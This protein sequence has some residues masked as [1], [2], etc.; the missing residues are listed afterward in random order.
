MSERLSQKFE[1]KIESL[2]KFEREYGFFLREA[3]DGVFLF[4]DDRIR[5]TNKRFDE[6]FGH[7]KR[8]PLL[9]ES[10]RALFFGKLQECVKR[11]QEK[12]VRSEKLPRFELTVT[13]DD[14]KKR[15]L[16]VAVSLV[17]YKK[18]PAILGIA[19]NI[20]SRN[21][22]SRLS[23]GFLAMAAHEVRTALTLITGYNRLLLAKKT[24]SL[25][26]PQYK[27]VKECNQSCDRFSKFLNEVLELLH[28]DAG[29]MKL[30]NRQED[31]R[32]S[33]KNVLRELG[34]EA[35]QKNIL[36]VETA[37]KGGLPIKVPM[38]R[39]KI[40]LVLMN[41]IKN[42]IQYTPR[43]GKIKIQPSISSKGSIRVCI[44]DTGIGVPPEERDTIFQE[45]KTG[46]NSKTNHGIGLGLAICRK[47]IELHGGKIW[48]ESRKEEGGSRFIFSLPSLRS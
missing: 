30:N 22:F 38:D 32:Q 48:V 20:S 28:L 46:R 15:E 25:T 3:S 16:E 5:L 43:G 39:N 10:G 44:A 47:I 33:I 42:A 21:E 23:S 12:A 27:I 26:P 34:P 1:R 24:G 4:Q 13:K 41:L 8:L 40:E 31:I 18:K 35:K 14:G 17:E 11:S 19:K 45:F 37:R 9:K 6:L 36:M 29:E 7:P 2:K